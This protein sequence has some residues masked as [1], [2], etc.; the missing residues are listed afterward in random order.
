MNF[1]VPVFQQKRGATVEW[2]TVGLG[3][4]TR[5]R[6]G[7]VPAKVRELLVADLRKAIEAA[8]S[9]EVV[10]LLSRRGTR[11][12]RVRLELT[13]ASAGA[14]RR[15]SG[16]YPLVLEPRELGSDRRVTIAYHPARQ[17]EWFPIKDELPLE[18]QAE[19][20]YGKAWSGLDDAA[21]ERL[22]SNGKDLLRVV[23]FSA[24]PRTL[25]DELGAAER[26]LWADLRADPARSKPKRASRGLQVLPGLG[27]DL[28]AEIVGGAPA[29]MPRAPYRAELEALLSAPKRPP[30]CVVGAP[31]V[32]KTTLLRQWIADLAEA[33]GF[34]AHHNL[35]RLTHVWSVS[36]K[37]LIAGMSYVGDWEQRCMDLLEDVRGK[38]IVLFVPDLFRFG[39]LGRARG[40][41]RSLADFFRGPVARGELALV[42]EA[43]SEQLFR[44]EEDAPAFAGLLVR[45]PVAEA[46][47]AEAFRVLVHEA[48]ALE[49]DR[50]VEISPLAL[51]AVI[52]LGAAVGPSRALPGRA[53]ELL[54]SV[55]E[56][57]GAGEERAE[58]SRAI[59]PGDSPARSPIG[60]AEVVACL[61][62]RAGVPRA[63][64]TREAVVTRAE[65]E[66]QL[67]AQVL[68]QPEAVR[69]AAD[70]VLRLKAGLTDPRRP[71]AV[72]LFTGPTGTGKTELAK[73]IAELVFGGG[74][75]LVRFDM[76]E[77]GGPDAAPR[78]VGDAASP[79]GQLTRAVL[80]QPLSV[81]LLDEI[82]KAH[83][84]VLNLLLQLF[85]DGRLTDAAGSTARFEGTVVI[86]TSNLGA[87]R[88]EPIGW[89]TAP[90]ALL[91]DVARAVREFFPPELFNRI[92]AVV[93]FRPLDPEVAIE[94]TEKE[95]AK[96]T[97]RQGLEARNVFVQANRAVVA[98]VAEEAFGT[99]DGARSL[100]RVLEDR[101]GAALAEAI[102]RAPAAVFRML[103]LFDAAS[104]REPFVLCDE[105]LSEAAPLDGVVYALEQLEGATVEEL[106]ARLAGLLP[107]IDEARHAA[108][109][110]RRGPIDV[111]DAGAHYWAEALDEALDALGARIEE[112]VPGLR[113]SSAP[114][115][116]P[117][118]G[119]FESGKGLEHTRVRVRLR[120]S[121]GGRGRPPA[122]R[123]ELLACF[124]RME[125]LGRVAPRVA[126][127]GAHAVVLE[128]VRVASP[129][130]AR[131]ADGLAAPAGAAPASLMRWLCEAYLGWAKGLAAGQGSVLDA[132]AA[133]APSGDV[134]EL[135]GETAVLEAARAGPD[136]LVLSLAGLGVRDAFAL[137]EGCHVW[138]PLATSPEIVR[139]RVLDGA[140]RPRE[141]AARFADARRRFLRAAGEASGGAPPENPSRL[142][143]MVRKL[144]FDPPRDGATAA[145]ELEDYAMGF[146]AEWPVTGATTA[147]ERLLWLR[148]SRRSIGRG[149]AS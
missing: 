107:G 81:V 80:E 56:H 38:R 103:Y 78:L 89:G 123:A 39:R 76:S 16:L 24:T 124:A 22:A 101:V 95:L 85:E 62:S 116:G 126:E 96:L 44:L 90:D 63:L 128:I 33:E 20:W 50:K 92:D 134:R 47:P 143:P 40:S 43:T 114:D 122:R 68:G 111:A 52:E 93:P 109:A 147:L 26:D 141:V 48:R 13:L 130:R 41:D 64:L 121:T 9:R 79:E 140:E 67:A 4:F 115:S 138:Q 15:V 12:V 69:A 149:D 82:D 17:G 117:R 73:C 51:R 46:T 42:G 148:A 83:P 100:K 54:R 97:S 11:L 91:S 87:R 98:R 146:S 99:R 70:L 133:L 120:S 14:R 84:S 77:L 66:R 34:A 61:S 36:G 127:A 49:A 125:H 55:V 58:A 131:F 112:H 60:P 53:V 8:L 118:W 35:D 18:M 86:M 119:T 30:V 27:I 65:V 7:T 19:S 102:A 31:G 2:T 32:G 21:I 6:S 37:R 3:P 137:E 59:P 106:R 29:G 144:R 105:P 28:T 136:L 88:R 23:A 129:K 45:L 5:S 132:G 104:A 1:S 74:A 135:R 145:L 57:D 139:V 113:R 72:Y 108:A 75:R 94:V 25:L 110:A 71:A 10:P 142:L